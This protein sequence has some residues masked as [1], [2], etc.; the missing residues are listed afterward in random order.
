MANGKKLDCI[1]FVIS[2]VS[3][4]MAMRYAKS[5][6]D[7]FDVEREIRR[8]A[9]I[10]TVGQLSGVLSEARAVTDTPVWVVYTLVKAHVRD[11]AE[12]LIHE[13]GLAATDVMGKGLA[14]LSRLLGKNP[15]GIPQHKLT[16]DYHRRDYAVDFTNSCDDGKHLER[17]SLADLVLVG[18][19][20]SG[21]TPLGMFL[22]QSA[23]LRVANVPV[24]IDLSL[25][26]E[27][28]KVDPRKVFALWPDQRWLEV[29]R[30]E[31]LSRDDP[32]KK[33]SG[34]YADPEVIRAELTHMRRLTAK[35][36]WTP[37]TMVGSTEEVAASIIYAWTERFGRVR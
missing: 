31:R 4:D 7:Q 12:T 13:S 37:I 10:S 24:V 18:L 5:L 16:P 30:S 33:I 35:R 14:D 36:T 22:A 17:L 26:E 8:Y 20:R 6:F 23:G 34:T 27:L 29:A 1:V 21:K 19:S 28:E 11:A 25:P 3:G 32:Q 9:G 2:D 15:L